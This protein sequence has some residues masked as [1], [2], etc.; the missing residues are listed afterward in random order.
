MN[1][2]AMKDKL[3]EWVGGQPAKDSSVETGQ[4]GPVAMQSQTELPGTEFMR[5]LA[6]LNKRE[7][8]HAAEKEKATRLKELASK[9]A[10]RE[11]E[12]LAGKDPAEILA[13]RAGHQEDEKKAD[14]AIQIVK[15]ER[16]NLFSAECERIKAIRN[17][18]WLKFPAEMIKSLKSQIVDASISEKQVQG[19]SIT[20]FSEKSEAYKEMTR[21]D[22]GIDSFNELAKENKMSDNS[23][24]PKTLKMVG[25]YE[26]EVSK[27][28]FDFKRRSEDVVK[29]FTSASQARASEASERAKQLERQNQSSGWILGKK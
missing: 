21:V 6:E 1:A 9:G 17:A 2:K 11:R 15:D 3:V 12:E 14:R 26:A 13:V 8:Q 16:S 4:D 29:K 27:T 28:I 7:A 10:A 20:C 24:V 19:L 25:P 23:F 22:T 18:V 5:T